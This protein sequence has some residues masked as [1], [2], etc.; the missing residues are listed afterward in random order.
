MQH[1]ACIQGWASQGDGLEVTPFLKSWICMLD[2]QVAMIFGHEPLTMVARWLDEAAILNEN[3]ILDP[4]IGCSAKLPKLMVNIK[5]ILEEDEA[6][7]NC[8]NR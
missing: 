2:C 5:P 6:I 7:S 1:Y 4:T 8:T 3:G